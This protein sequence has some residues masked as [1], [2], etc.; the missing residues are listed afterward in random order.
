MTPINKPKTP[1]I[2]TAGAVLGEEVYALKPMAILKIFS[3]KV[4][5]TPTKAPAIIAVQ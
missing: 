3:K 1:P 4:S 2:A 5:P